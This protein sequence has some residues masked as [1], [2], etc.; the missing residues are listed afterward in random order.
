MKKLEIIEELLKDD[1]SSL[2]DGNDG[3]QLLLSIL[4]EGFVGYTHMTLKEL[5]QELKTRGY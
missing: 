1:N 4:R 3:H 5:K 2:L